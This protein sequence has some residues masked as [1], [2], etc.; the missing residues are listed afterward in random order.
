M[1][2]LSIILAIFLAL[3]TTGC[4]IKINGK[5]FTSIDVTF[6]DSSGNISF[7]TSGK[8]MEEDY[9]QKIYEYLLIGK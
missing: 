3:I 6:E 1:K 5:E 9:K 2:K 7:Y 8:P 4:S